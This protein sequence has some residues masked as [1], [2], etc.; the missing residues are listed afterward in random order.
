MKLMSPSIFVSYR[1]VDTGH[2][3]GRLRDWLVERVAPTQVFM[4][5]SVSACSVLLAIIGKHWISVRDDQ[6]NFRLNN[7]RDWV[8]LEIKTALAR[9]IHVVPVLVDGAPMPG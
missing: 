7:P 2:A 1:R 8:V 4:D 9:D 6:G 5:D 3:A